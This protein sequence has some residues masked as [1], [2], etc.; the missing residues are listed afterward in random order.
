MEPTG[1]DYRFI[2][3]RQDDLR[4][5]ITIGEQEVDS[6]VEYLFNALEANSKD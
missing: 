3:L 1:C 6:I 4:L 5:S 2:N